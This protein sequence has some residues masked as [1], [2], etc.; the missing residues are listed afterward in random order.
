MYFSV[1]FLVLK[2]HELLAA[3]MCLLCPTFESEIL[4][5]IVAT[6]EE[7]EWSFQNVP[8]D[9]L[10]AGSKFLWSV[11]SSVHNVN[12]GAELGHHSRRVIEHVLLKY[13]CSLSNGDKA[14]AVSGTV[15]FDLF[16]LARFRA[17]ELLSSSPAQVSITTCST[18]RIF[19]LMFV[20]RLQRDVGLFFLGDGTL[21]DWLLSTQWEQDV[22]WESLRVN[23][24]REQ[25]LD[26]AVLRVC[27]KSFDRV[28]L[29]FFGGVRIQQHGGGDESAASAL[30]EGAPAGS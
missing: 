3:G 7:K 26:D 18:R 22:F 1:C 30:L 21:F 14:E 23:V 16:L 19:C 29:L 9:Q 2:F 10:V 6:I 20:L 17:R 8:V 24:P 5:E 11:V 13:S 15:K 4:T 12:L 25:L 28:N 27:Q